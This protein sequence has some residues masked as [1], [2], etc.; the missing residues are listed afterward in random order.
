MGELIRQSS[1]LSFSANILIKKEDG[2]FIA[3]CLELDIV[4][5]AD[6]VDQARRECVALICAQI[7]YA[8]A[9]DNLAN[10]YHP[11]PHDVWA[12]FY[13]CKAQDELRYKLET[14]LDEENPAAIMPPWLIAKTC[15]SCHA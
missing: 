1:D 9:H 13:A 3:H 6:S 12:E 10:L 4:A 15:Q 8:F 7:E 2:L 11:A 14:R 5:V